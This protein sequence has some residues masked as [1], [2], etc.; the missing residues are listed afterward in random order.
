MLL[1]T[2]GRVGPPTTTNAF[3]R[4][5][6]FPGGYIPALSEVMPHI[7]KS[8]LMVTDVEILRLHYA[9]TLKAWRER[10][11]AK[12]DQVK[13]I[14]DERFCRMWDFYLAGSEASFRWQDLVNFQIQ[15]TRRNDVL[16]MTRDY[17][18]KCEKAI[19]MHEMG[20]QP[21]RRIGKPETPAEVKPAVKPAR[22]RKVAGKE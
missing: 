6:I 12:W 2:I 7:E 13:A 18:G 5:H 14:Y 16:P 11:R 4:R 22:R 21:D 15:L 3:I 10:F 8:G 17:I 1:H 9:E 19:A 20:H